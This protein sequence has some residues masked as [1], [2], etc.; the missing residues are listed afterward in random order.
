MDLVVIVKLMLSLLGSTAI[1]VIGISYLTY[2]TKK[3]ANRLAPV[4]SINPV[5][6]ASKPAPV[7]TEYI[8][9]RGE[10][11]NFAP[12]VEPVVETA[13]VSY[14]EQVA[15]NSYREQENSREK[16]DRFQVLN[17]QSVNSP[18]FT[19]FSTE[20]PFYTPAGRTVAYETGSNSKILSSYAGNNEPMYR[21]NY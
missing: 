19:R 4:R 1:I 2:R 3:K 20:R 13:R 16:R 7:A 11:R 14:M 12:A 8:V 9:H 10:T 15:Y 5:A 6:V 21:M 17:N 18:A